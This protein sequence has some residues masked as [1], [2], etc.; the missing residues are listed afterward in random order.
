MFE[1]S[2]IFR[3]PRFSPSASRTFSKPTPIAAWRSGS[4]MGKGVRES[5]RRVNF[6]QDVSDPHRRHS[7]I[8]IE[9]QFLCAFGN[10]CGQPVDPQRSIFNA[11]MGAKSNK[12]G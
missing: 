3:R 8:K 9:D 10:V 4:E 2:A 1:A 5:D 12:H 6:Q 11:T 7:T